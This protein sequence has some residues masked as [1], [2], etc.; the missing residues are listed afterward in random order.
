VNEL[1]AE[2]QKLYADASKH[3][4]YQNIPD[5]V[6]AEIG[7]SETIDENWRGDRPRLAY[8]MG[9]RQPAAGESWLD[10][11]ANTGFFTLSLARE[12]PQT[13]FFAVEANANH[14]RFITR[15][16]QYFGMANIEVIQR[17]IG[18]AD[19]HELPHS[20]C[21]MHLNVLHHAG[22]DFDTD[23]V[24][25]KSEFAN[26]AVR[27]LGLLRERADGM[28]FQM[29]SNWG[30]DKHQPLV[31]V[32]EDVVK[33]ETL[34]NWLQLAGWRVTQVAYATRKADDG[35]QFANLSTPAVRHMAGKA[36]NRDAFQAE[37][38]Q[39]RLDDFPGEFY[40]R[41]LFSCRASHRC[42]PE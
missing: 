22:H 37:L 17:A 8:L 10:F 21:L 24:P 30:G 3:S 29:G 2:L 32:R 4:V 40:R 33:L 7:Y 13:R 26:Y 15:V 6:S 35:V 23:L 31:G 18:L 36:G 41:P 1:K 34:S 12:F 38:D 16:A 27:Y 28:F 14:A 9:S 20:D 42:I 19:L 39:F 5:F 11:G 25:E